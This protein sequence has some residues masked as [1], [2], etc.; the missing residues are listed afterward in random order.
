MI[1]SSEREAA[2]AV[3]VPRTISSGRV[4]DKGRLKLPVEVK[5]YLSS[6]NDKLFIT[7]FDNRVIRIYS[8]KAWR[9][10]E[11]FL[12]Q[13]NGDPD[14]TED[15]AFLA[16]NYGDVAEIDSQGRVLLP[17]KL[18]K[19]MNLENEP[20][21][22]QYHKGRMNVFGKDVYEERHARARDRAAEK[23]RALEAKGFK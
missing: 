5:E 9:D 2:P 10:N 23:L 8:M 13:P 12:D 11:Y 1:E 22:L 7:S 16:Q 19:E 6:F 3:D 17:Q 14:D 20:V 18:R 15:I 4:D 21:W